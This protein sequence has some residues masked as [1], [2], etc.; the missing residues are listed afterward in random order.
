MPQRAA[1]RAPAAGPIRPPAV[2]LLS[3][4]V[5]LL[6]VLLLAVRLPAVRRRRIPRVPR[7]TRA[8][9]RIR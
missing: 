2:V 6:A 5:L 3:A 9:G 7:R 8:P 1:V 4:V